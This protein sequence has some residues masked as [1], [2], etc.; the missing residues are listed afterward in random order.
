MLQHRATDL[1][2]YETL[3]LFFSEEQNTKPGAFRRRGCQAGICDALFD[4]LDRRTLALFSQMRHRLST[5][6]MSSARSLSLELSIRL[7]TPKSR[8]LQQRSSK[9][10]RHQTTRGRYHKLLSSHTG[11]RTPAT[12]H[13]STRTLQF[14][15]SF[16]SR[17]SRI[18]R[19]RR[20]VEAM[21]G[22]T[23]F[24]ADR[25]YEVWRNQLELSVKV[26]TMLV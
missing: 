23:S 19:A 20:G 11:K 8:E 14:L 22:M 1:Q 15:T 16:R 21:K 2:T 9:I 3:Y 6:I 5:A 26:P 13:I 25:Y 12:S 18:W 10:W 24:R 7:T 17:A 4:S